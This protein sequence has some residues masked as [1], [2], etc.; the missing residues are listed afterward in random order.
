MVITARHLKLMGA[1]PEII[2]TWRAKQICVTWDR[3]GYRMDGVITAR[4][5]SAG[6]VLRFIAAL[7]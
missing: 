1:T 6:E 4:K 2:D 3:D 7:Q 5:L